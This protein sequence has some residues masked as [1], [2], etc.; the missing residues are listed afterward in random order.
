MTLVARRETRREAVLRFST[1][2][3][4]ALCKAAVASRSD[5]FASAAFFW[6]T[7]LRTFRMAP[8]TELSTARFRW[9][10]FSACRARLMVDLWIT[11]GMVVL[12]V[13]R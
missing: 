8:L 2:L 9:W 4:T 1:P 3:L 5:A 7:A 11:G 12:Q 13:L 6:S 10:R